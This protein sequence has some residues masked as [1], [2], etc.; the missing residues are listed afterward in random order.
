MLDRQKKKHRT[1]KERGSHYHFNSYWFLSF[2]KSLS[3][4]IIINS[5][6]FSALKEFSS[7][8]V[9][10]KMVFQCWEKPSCSTLSL[11]SF[12]S[13]AFHSISNSSH[14]HLI[15]ETGPLSSTSLFFCPLLQG[16]GNR[17]P[18]CEHLLF[19]R[20]FSHILQVENTPASQMETQ[21]L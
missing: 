5:G 20:P 13:A 1:E 21:C 11:G 3:L 14:I 4:K 18:N 16:K 2:F 19:S 10:F 17:P 15:D 9:Q 7:A 6:T 12:C 8:H